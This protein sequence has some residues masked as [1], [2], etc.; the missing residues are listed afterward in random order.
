MHAFHVQNGI[1]DV[2]FI[3]TYSKSVR[4]SWIL[5]GRPHQA[6]KIVPALTAECQGFM[7]HCLFQHPWQW[8]Y[9]MHMVL[10]FTLYCVLL[11]FSVTYCPEMP[12]CFVVRMCGTCPWKHPQVLRP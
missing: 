4:V 2:N 12:S 1:C 8:S 7:H 5:Y 6:Q 9:V 10:L 3:T 11:F